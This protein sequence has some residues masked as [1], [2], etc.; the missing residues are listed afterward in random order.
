MPH[1]KISRP[2][3]LGL[4]FQRH[5][6]GSRLGDA[7][8]QQAEMA[9]IQAS[10]GGQAGGGTAHPVWRTRRSLL[11]HLQA[12]EVAGRAG[13]SCWTL[14]ACIAIGAA[15]LYLLWLK[16]GAHKSSCL[17]SCASSSYRDAQPLGRRLCVRHYFR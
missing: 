9:T 3:W 6:N 10:G 1:I 11:P 15:A 5:W 14:G 17:A 4:A 7:A 13:V 2:L 16:L 8:M 12:D